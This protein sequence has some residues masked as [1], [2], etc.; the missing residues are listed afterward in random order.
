LKLQI[1]SLLLL[2]TARPH[3]MA[4]DKPATGNVVMNMATAPLDKLRDIVE[5]WG[6]DPIPSAVIRQQ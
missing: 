3:T 5:R 6:M 2:L 4:P 1:V